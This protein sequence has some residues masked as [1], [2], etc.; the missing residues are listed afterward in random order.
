MAETLR[1]QQ[2]RFALAV[3]KLIAHAYTLGYEVTLGDAYRDPRVFGPMGSVR[4]YGRANSQHKQR[5]AIDLNLFRDGRFLSS[6]ESHRP[7][8]EWWE[9]QHPDARWGGRFNDGNHYSLERGGF[10]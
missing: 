10:K 7:L 4:G 2:S 5:L 6:T 3:S 1:Q 9:R 8:G